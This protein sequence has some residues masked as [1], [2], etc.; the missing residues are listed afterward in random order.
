MLADRRPNSCESPEMREIRDGLG[1]APVGAPAVVRVFR[2][3]TGAWCV[4]RDG[5]PGRCEFPD[6]Q[7][8]R[9]WARV[10]VARCR[11]YHLLVASD[12]GWYADEYFN[13]P[14]PHPLAAA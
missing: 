10:S 11:S 5:V 4:T 2:S 14:T 9:L 13:W 3:E 7:S 8:A 12:S 1:A 6:R